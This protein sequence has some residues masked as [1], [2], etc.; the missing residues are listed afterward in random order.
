MSA[1]ATGRY[2]CEVWGYDIKFY[3]RTRYAHQGEHKT[4][5]TGQ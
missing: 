1:Q 2:R 3:S 4:T 5:V